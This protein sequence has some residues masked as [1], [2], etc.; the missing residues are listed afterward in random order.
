MYTL[1]RYCFKEYKTVFMLDLYDHENKKG[2]ELNYNL[3]NKTFR[4]GLSD[5]LYELTYK[6]L[7]L[8]EWDNIVHQFITSK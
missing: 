8:N 4:S 3:Y 2:V 7:P 5:I 6:T 1:M